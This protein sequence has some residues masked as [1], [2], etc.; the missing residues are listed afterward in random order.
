MFPPENVKWNGRGV[1]TNVRRTR[2]NGYFKCIC[3]GHRV[4]RKQNKPKTRIRK[5]AERY[6]DTRGK[7]RVRNSE[8]PTSTE[9]ERF[10]CVYFFILKLTF[11][12]LKN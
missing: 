12:F 5:K 1:Q 2:W 8:V 4:D 10:N 11:L 3:L 7:I 9:T 6:D